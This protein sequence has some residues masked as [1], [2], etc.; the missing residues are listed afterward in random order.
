MQIPL[1][2]GAVLESRGRYTISQRDEAVIDEFF[3][4]S[5]RNLGG[6]SVKPRRSINHNLDSDEA[7]GIISALPRFVCW[8]TT[9]V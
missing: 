3:D 9:P 7:Y 4:K 6:S 5:I 8:T 1:K 2:E